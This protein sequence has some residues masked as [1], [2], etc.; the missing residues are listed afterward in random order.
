M[1]MS[2]I[3]HETCIIL[4][5]TPANTDLAMSDALQMAK[6]ADLSGSRTIGVITKLDIMDKGTNA[7]NF[8]L[9]KAVP[10]HLGYVGVINRCQA[11]INQNRSVGEALASEENFFRNHP[12][13]SNSLHAIL[14]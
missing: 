2:Y 12:V 9:G 3:K 4:A 11:D 13:A 10:L 14:L 6:S 7:C 8:L 5:V 1:I